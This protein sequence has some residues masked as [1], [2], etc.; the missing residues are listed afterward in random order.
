MQYKGNRVL[1]NIILEH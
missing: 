1:V